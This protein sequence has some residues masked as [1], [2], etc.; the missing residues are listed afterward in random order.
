MRQVTMGNPDITNR[1]F[2]DL[3]QLKQNERGK[4][5]D[6]KQKETPHVNQTELMKEYAGCSDEKRR[7]EIKDE[8]VLANQAFVVSMARH[9]SSGDD[10]N[11]LISEGNIGLMK[12]IDAFNIENENNFLTYAA[13]W[14]RKMMIEYIILSKRIVKPKNPIRVYT[15]SESAKNKYFCENGWFPTEEETLLILKEKGVPLSNEKDLY[16]ISISSIDSDFMN[17]DT[18]TTDTGWFDKVCYENDYDTENL[19]NVSK[20]MENLT[21]KSL[22]SKSL[23]YL[24]DSEKTVVCQYFGI[25]ERQQTPY[26]IGLRLGMKGK[27]PED[28]KK[29]ERKVEKLIKKYIQ[30]IRKNGKIETDVQ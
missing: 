29:I 16:T 6:K 3:R 20:H 26:E 8:I 12:A 28:I 22:V 27:T 19:S 23:S 30:K 21:V 1:F 4:K 9:L 15:Y 2:K 13:H 11:D 5:S 24:E 7:Q 18:D 14:I 17:D 25:G 10:F